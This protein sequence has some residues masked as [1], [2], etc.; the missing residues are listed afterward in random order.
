MAKSFPI[1]TSKSSICKTRKSKVSCHSPNLCGYWYVMPNGVLAIEFMTL[2]LLVKCTID[3]WRDK[4]P[5]IR[6][7]KKVYMS[8]M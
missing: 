3:N 6:L 5:W 4:N 7:I 2:I 1:M 8:H